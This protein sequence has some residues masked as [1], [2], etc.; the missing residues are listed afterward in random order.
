MSSDPKDALGFDE[1]EDLFDFAGASSSGGSDDDDIDIAEFLSTIDDSD[2]SAI[3][4]LAESE[5]AHRTTAASDDVGAAVK[6]ARA[7]PAPSAAVPRSANDQQVVVATSGP[8]WKQPGAIA[9]LSVGVALL[10]ANMFGVWA[11]WTN[12]KSMVQEVEATRI[13]IAATIAR[14]Q[15]ELGDEYA[16]LENATRPATAAALGTASFA[17]VEERLDIGD[18][19]AARRLLYAKLA[20]LDRLP[21]A[22]RNE[23]EARALFMLAETDRAQAIGLAA[24]PGQGD[25]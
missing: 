4:D 25:A 7:T 1:D 24:E 15:R 6:P 23:V 12:N 20:L 14:A 10:L 8:F 16:R 2:A 22:Q 19:A 11:T 17:S 13:D 21:P 5:D 9:F 18:F 3:L